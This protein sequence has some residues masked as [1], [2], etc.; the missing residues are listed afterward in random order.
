MKITY[1]EVHKQIMEIGKKETRVV[2]GCCNSLDVKEIEPILATMDFFNCNDRLIQDTVYMLNGMGKFRVFDW[3][4]TE[5][6]TLSRGGDEEQNVSALKV[7]SHS[8]IK[9]KGDINKF[10]YD[11]RTTDY[12]IDTSWEKIKIKVKT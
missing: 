5:I 9:T 6:D 12:Q 2:S 3:L 8:Y 10:I 11:L 4:A 7:L 1:D